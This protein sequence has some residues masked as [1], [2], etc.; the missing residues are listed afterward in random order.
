MASPPD[1]AYGGAA[2]A[3]V[4]PSY[5]INSSNKKRIVMKILIPEIV[6]EETTGFD[7]NIDI[8]G[9][10]GFGE[11]LANLIESSDDNPVIALDS[12][13]GEGKSTF[14]KMWQGYLSHHR[15]EKLRTIYFDAF[16]ND[17]QKD[18]FVTLAAEI[19]QLIEPEDEKGKAEFQEKA[20]KQLSRLLVEQ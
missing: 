7:N 9:R 6:I 11:R 2:E 4:I 5:K 8:F 19:Y 13:W 1:A 20:K 16:E 12:G 10:S 17:Y 15:E 14:I 3:G 18:P